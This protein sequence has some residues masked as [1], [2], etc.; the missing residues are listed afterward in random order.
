LLSVAVIYFHD[1][2]FVSPDDAMTGESA[3]PWGADE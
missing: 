3:A 2:T 1:K